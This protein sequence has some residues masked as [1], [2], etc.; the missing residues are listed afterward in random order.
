MIAA[1]TNGRPAVDYPALVRLLVA[2][3]AFLVAGAALWTA[4]PHPDLRRVL[5]LV[6]LEGVVVLSWIADSVRHHGALP[7]TMGVVGVLALAL[8]SYP[9]A[10]FGVLMAVLSAAGKL[11]PGRAVALVLPLVAVFELVERSRPG[12]PPPIA[13]E[14]LVLAGAFLAGAG[15]RGLRLQRERRRAAL[16]ELRQLR[17]VQ[18]RAE[19]VA[20]RVRLANDVHE[21]LGRTLS[22]LRSEL[23]RT[24]RLLVEAE[25]EGP[26]LTAL[27][28]A[29][30]LVREAMEEARRARGTLR[31]ER[32][33]GPALLAALLSEFEGESGIQARL[34]VEG[35]PVELAPEGRLA[36]YRALQQALAEGGKREQA[37]QVEARLRYER[38]G[39]ELSVEYVP[40]E[41]AAETLAG[42]RRRAELLGGRLEIGSAGDVLR[43]RLWVP[44]GRP[45]ADVL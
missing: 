16:A 29:H 19:R 18:D 28:R 30:R 9:V 4:G 27:D 2:A 37:R 44:A 17:E 21:K 35:D 12:R 38:E 26:A 32:P 41:R 6:F 23:E 13:A 33:P 36:L 40:E 1:M 14:V 24:Q 22:G 11:S 3:A 8:G 7:L 45:H 20:E 39:A 25:A 34:R 10:A 43:V 5:L 31:G 15:A 42:L